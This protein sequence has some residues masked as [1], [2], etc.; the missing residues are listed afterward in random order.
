MSDQTT[1]TATERPEKGPVPEVTA[2]V[3]LIKPKNNLIAFANINLGGHYAVNDIP[4]KTGKN[5]IFF[6]NPVKPNDRGGYEDT[7]LPTSKE[8]REA[9]TTAITQ[10]YELRLEKHQAIGEAQKEVS[11]ARASIKDQL[12]EGAIAAAAQTPSAPRDTARREAA[13]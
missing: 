6:D 8:M 7:S 3:R 9:I 13:L 10:A 12:R 11:E 1:N 5:G 2:S 4:V